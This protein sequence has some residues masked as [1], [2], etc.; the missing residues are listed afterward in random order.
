MCCKSKIKIVC[1]LNFDTIKKYKLSKTDLI[2]NIINGYKGALCIKC[3]SS[4]V[5]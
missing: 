5:D 2:K 4:K 1:Q 3:G